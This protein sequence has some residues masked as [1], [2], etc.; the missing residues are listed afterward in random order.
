MLDDGNVREFLEKPLGDGGWIN[1]GFFVLSPKVLDYVDGDA[2]AWEG[3]P[4][5]KLAKE[6]QLR[7]YEHGLFWQA[8][9]TVRDKHK[10]EEL[11]NA[12]MPPWK[13]W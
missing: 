11:W 8:M 10:L 12:G 4:L 6:G 7:A 2:T 13:L 9:D 5:S 3:E 1:G